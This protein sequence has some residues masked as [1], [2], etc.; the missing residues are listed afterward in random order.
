VVC[1]KHGIRGDGEYCCG[2]DAQL[3]RI[4][5]FYHE[6]SGGKHVSR[7]VL[8]DLKPGVIGTL[9]ASSLGELFRPVNLVNQNVGAGNNWAKGHYKKA[10]KNSA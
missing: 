9:R 3:D 2:N 7:A 1:G 4:S 10:G 5:A 8:F 6:A